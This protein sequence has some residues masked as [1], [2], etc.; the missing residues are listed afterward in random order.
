MKREGAAHFAVFKVCRFCVW[1]IRQKEK[2]LSSSA[3]SRE[4][5][6][7][8]RAEETSH[9]LKAAKR[10]GT[11]RFCLLRLRSIRCWCK[12]CLRHG[13]QDLHGPPAVPGK[14]NGKS[15]GKVN[16]KVNGQSRSLAALGMTSCWLSA[17]KGTYSAR[18]II[19]SNTLKI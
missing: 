9:S 15:N 3:S 19:S 12:K 10:C 2:L 5:R 7:V 11:Q 6:S 16:G 8:A 17:G 13:V 1:A 18:C 14:V 4:N